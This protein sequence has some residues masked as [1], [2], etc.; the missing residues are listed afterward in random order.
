MY[1]VGIH[2]MVSQA[3]AAKLLGNVHPDVTWRSEVKI[4]DHTRIDFMGTTSQG[5]VVYV[6]VKNA[7]ISHQVETM[8]RSQR[9]AVFPEG[10][11]KSKADTF[12]PRALKHATI[13]GALAKR[14]ETEAAYLLYIVPRHDCGD[15]LELNHADP[16]YRAG[17]AQA[18]ADGVQVRVFGLRFDDQGTICLDQPL[19]FH[20]NAP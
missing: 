10:Y 15:G 1:C 14:P 6:E 3:M 5:K 13:L 12:S 20:G 4:D 7:M 8:G 17:V 2:P 18:L 9:R 16:I 11:R 19:P